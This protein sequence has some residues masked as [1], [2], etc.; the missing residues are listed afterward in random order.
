MTVSFFKGSWE[1]E[2]FSCTHCL[3]DKKNQVSDS[4]KGDIE[5]LG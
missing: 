5:D 1:M 4:K 2:Y 3:L